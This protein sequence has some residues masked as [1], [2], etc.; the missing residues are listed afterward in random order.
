MTILYPLKAQN[1]ILQLSTNA[2]KLPLPCTIV[3]TFFLMLSK[4]Y[5]LC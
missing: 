2:L 5:V 3:S 1:W 4:D